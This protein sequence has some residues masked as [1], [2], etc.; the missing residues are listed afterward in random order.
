M[1][2]KLKEFGIKD[3]NIHLVEIISALFQQGVSEVVI[4]KNEI[5]LEEFDKTIDIA[6]TQRDFEKIKVKAI[7]EGIPY[8]ALV[9]MLIH[10]YNEGKIVLTI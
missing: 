7:E 5:K 2:T 9:S 4:R 1:F 10:N 6:L 3:L 8:Q